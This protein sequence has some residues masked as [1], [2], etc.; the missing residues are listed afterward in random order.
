MITQPTATVETSLAVAL[1][2]A[3][4]PFFSGWFLQAR[5]YRREASN[6]ATKVLRQYRDPLLRAAYDL[7]SRIYNIV[8]REYLDWYWRRGDAAQK[9]N[10]IYGTLWLFGQYLGW[11]EILR[12]EIQ[13]LDVGSRL[14]NQQI[15]GCL[16]QISAAL[17]T[18]S[19][20]L[21]KALQI[22]RGEQR[23]VG[24]F[25]I[26]GRVTPAEGS[27]P[28]CLGYSE[29]IRALPPLNRRKFGRGDSY[30]P[31][32]TWR[33]RLTDDLERAGAGG[34]DHLPARLA[35]VQRLLVDLVDLLDPDRS[36]IP[37]P[38]YRG[39][40]PRPDG[41]EPVGAEQLARFIWPWSD[42]WPEVEKWAA[43]RHLSPSRRSADTHSYRGRRGPTLRRPE[44]A[45]AYTNRRLIVNGCSRRGG[46][47]APIDG[48]LRM[49]R[50]RSATNDLLRG[51]E[52]PP[53]L[54][55]TTVPARLG[56]TALEFLRRLRGRPA[57]GLP[58]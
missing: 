42:P 3:L 44:F 14:A 40:L 47:R 45:I 17:S 48:S 56:S 5:R 19:P 13:Y 23:A 24:D 12:R 38:D 28:D 7:Q 55:R 35:T 9:E 50:A 26:A 8:A 10:A 15:Q 30:S 11:T 25:M 52:R 4:I 29:F 51:F 58:S 41:S 49:L 18:D 36:R 2:V 6:E 33:A 39:R 27:R 20:P 46:S 34:T 53:I 57:A 22:V 21:G 43:R 16:N 31:V 54:G 1:A 32:A 37:D